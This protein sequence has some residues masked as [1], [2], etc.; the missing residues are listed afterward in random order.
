MERFA[1]IPRDQRSRVRF[2][3]LNHTNP[4][5]GSQAP[6]RLR[7]EESGMRVAEEGEQYAL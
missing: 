4:L 3:H 7:L 5:L 2:I 1:D 6:E